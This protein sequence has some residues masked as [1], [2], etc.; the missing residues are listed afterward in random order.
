[1]Y[2]FEEYTSGHLI[3]DGLGLKLQPRRDFGY[4]QVLFRVVHASFY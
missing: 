3:L 1:M 4:G 2:A